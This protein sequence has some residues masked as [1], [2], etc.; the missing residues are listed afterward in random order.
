M[1]QTLRPVTL[2]NLYRELL[3]SGGVNG[4]PLSRRSVDYVHAVLRKALNDAVRSEQLLLSNPA[5]RAKRP[6]REPQ[7]KGTIWTA[8]QLRV[9]L[10]VIAEYRLGAFYWLA[11]H[12]GARR[13]EL[14]NLRWSDLDVDA[15]RVH[16]RGTV[17][18]VDGQRVEGT[19]KG[20]RERTV[21]ID[22]STA[23][24][25]REHRPAQEHDRE[26][27]GGSWV[28]GDH[29][30]RLALGGPL[31][32]D[33]VTA[34]MAKTL[35]AY[36]GQPGHE[37][38]PVVR[39]HDLRHIHAT[40]LLQAGVPVHVVAARLGHA[41]PAITLRVYAHVLQD[42]ELEAAE[43]FA[44]LLSRGREAACWQTR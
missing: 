28:P 40:L 9:F 6:R 29:V 22:E 3:A 16:I 15:G 19:T 17:G 2:S 37:P 36:N 41:D 38:L 27:A 23:A 44:G 18:I 4:R 20:G 14:L 5:E 33:T 1:L 11:A 30:F 32:P 8:D 12:R 34:L 10:D 35:R 39:F 31:F 26:V 42:Q 13:G 21:S 43:V 25:M 7:T 24:V